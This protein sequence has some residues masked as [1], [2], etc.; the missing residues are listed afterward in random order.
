[1]KPQ[2]GESRRRKASEP[3]GDDADRP[4]DLPHVFPGVCLIRFPSISLGARRLFLALATLGLAGAAACSDASTSNAANGKITVLLTDAPGDFKTAVV[5]ISQV[6]L[7]SGE[8]E[9]GGRVILRDTPITTDLLTLANSTADLV[10]DATLPAGTYAQL[11]FVITGGYVE[12]ENADG[13]TSIYASSPTYEGLPAGAQVAGSLQ[14]PSFAQ[15]GLKVQL[16][17]GGV[18]IDGEQKVVLVDFDVSRSFGKAAGGS[19]QWVMSPVL[20]ATSFATTGGVSVTLAKADGVTLPS[21]NNTPITL[22]QFKAVLE[23]GDG[24]KEELALTDANNDGIFEGT[25]LYVLPG[26]YTV[27]FVAPSDSVQFTTTPA[28]PIA[29]VVGSGSSASV[30]AVLT[31]A[32]K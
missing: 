2:A 25:F 9:D 17:E 14:L 27:D 10:K 4:D 20:T 19:G 15:S 23:T 3:T 11:R 32:T 28:R 7:Q 1:M 12:V 29:V 26:D 30:A 21:I 22:G 8:G 5:T 24:T 18:K 16:P 13:S 6:Y 31:A